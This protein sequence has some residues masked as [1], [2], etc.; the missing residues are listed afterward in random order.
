M[1]NISAETVRRILE[2]LSSSR[3]G[4]IGGSRQ[5][6]ARCGF[7][8]LHPGDRRLVY[9]AVGEIVL[10]VDEK[11]SLQARRRKSPT[12]LAQPA[13]PVQ[14]EQEYERK[15]ELNLFA[16]FDTRT[17]KVY[18]HT[19]EKRKRKKEFIEFLEKLDRAIPADIKTVHVVLDNRRMHKGK[20]VQA[21][22]AQ[23]SATKA[24]GDRRFPR[25][26]GLGGTIAQF[27]AEWNKVAKPF[28]WSKKSSPRSW[29]SAKRPCNPPR[30]QLATSGMISN[31]LHYGAVLRTLPKLPSDVR[32]MVKVQRAPA[33][34]KSAR[35]PPGRRGCGSYGVGKALSDCSATGAAPGLPSIATH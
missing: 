16:A 14:V 1:P 25:K 31:P 33:Q 21:W 8:R 5:D 9:P 3:G 19:A 23:H 15:G 32:D 4:I 6:A 34:T 10:C 7:R 18:G 30:D 26:G 27:I 28:N 24:S 13:R 35:S 29:P 11:T 22:L 2:N 20:Q 12:R 17:G